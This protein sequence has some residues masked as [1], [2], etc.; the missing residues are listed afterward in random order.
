MNNLDKIMKKTKMT[1][2][3]LEEIIEALKYLGLSPSDDDII[4]YCQ[5]ESIIIDRNI[6]KS[7]ICFD[8]GKRRSVTMDIDTLKKFNKDI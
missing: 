3:E 2:Q 4:R 5:D 1:K 8:C 7:S 6:E